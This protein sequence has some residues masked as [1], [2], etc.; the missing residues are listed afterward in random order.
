M[1]LLQSHPT[2]APEVFE[3]LF[4]AFRGS[5]HRVRLL[6][7]LLTSGSDGRLQGQVQPQ[8]EPLPRES[9][10]LKQQKIN[11]VLTK[12]LS[13]VSCTLQD[14]Q[15]AFD[16]FRV[17]CESGVEDSKSY[18]LQRAVQHHNA[19]F[20]ANREV[21]EGTTEAELRS[22]IRELESAAESKERELS[23]LKQGIAE[24]SAGM[25]ERQKL[26]K[27]ALGAS[28]HKLTAKQAEVDTLQRETATTI[29]G[30]HQ[31]LA[32][33]AQQLTDKKTAPDPSTRRME[34]LEMD[35][36]ISNY[37]L[38]AT[39]HELKEGSETFNQQL[40]AARKI[41]AE[42][43][44]IIERERS[45]ILVLEQ[46]L[47]E[48]TKTLASRSLRALQRL[49]YPD[50]TPCNTWSDSDDDVQTSPGVRCRSS[51]S[52][53]RIPAQ[54]C[55]ETP[56]SKRHLVTKIYPRSA[57]DKPSVRA[58]PGIL[59]NSAEAKRERKLY[60]D[61][62]G[63]FPP[64]PSRPWFQNLLPVG[65]HEQDETQFLQ[66]GVNTDRTSMYF[67]GRTIWCKEEQVHALLFGP[68]SEYRR[69]L[70]HWS[71][72]TTIRDLIGVEFDLFTRSGPSIF[73]SGIYTVHCLRQIHRPGSVLPD[74]LSEV[75]MNRAAGITDE[76]TSISPHTSMATECF[77]LQCVG[78]DLRLYETLRFRFATRTLRLKRKASQ[79]ELP[80]HRRK[81]DRT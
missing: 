71:P 42:Q 36:E 26:F 80:G 35:L 7:D 38:C 11:A 73:Y 8:R 39:T 22:K 62:M 52:T 70:S 31:A 2:L 55:D 5:Q 67:P 17:R 77:G 75:E 37:Q 19:V 65:T 34:K 78:F 20:D 24:A 57:L 68:T 41:N 51:R 29:Q 79:A 50:G 48:A 16:K 58:I 30:L 60:V 56:T 54:L 69:R 21:R 15:D 27:E 32:T 9:E 13:F 45:R 33:S 14:T 10:I 3:V 64:P 72:C 6:E 25:K 18:R 28:N 61:Y 49:G 4:N 12:V 66:H 74:D 47:A 1:D 44:E 23:L 59:Q 43:C 63:I 53:A 40:A 81:S 76:S 46:R